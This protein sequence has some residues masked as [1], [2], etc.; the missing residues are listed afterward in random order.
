[1]RKLFCRL[2][3]C[4]AIV[5]LANGCVRHTATSSAMGIGSHS[6]STSALH[7]GSLAMGSKAGASRLI[8]V[9]VQE[10][11]QLAPHLADHLG[12]ALSASNFRLTDSPSKAGHILHVNILQEGNAS[13]ASVQAAVKAGY[14]KKARFSGSGVRAVLADA[15]IV[16]RKAPS[17]KRPSRERM[18]NASSRN[19]LGSAQMRLAVLDSGGR[20]AVPLDA[21]SQAMARELARSITEKPAKAAPPA[22]MS[23]G[24]A[25]GKKSKK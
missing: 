24:T 10:N 23:S 19:A 8:Y 13:P 1:M 17:H 14:G 5:L 18:K 20:K 2:I 9:D 6:G 4:L 7:E 15:L 16:Q 12:K 25:P 11:A 21:F 22:K 3:F